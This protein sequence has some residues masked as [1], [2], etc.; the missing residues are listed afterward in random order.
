M[1]LWLCSIDETCAGR[2]FQRL[3][4]RPIFRAVGSADRDDPAQMI[5]RL[6]AVALFDLPQAVIL[7]R[8]HVVRIG[9]QRALV[10]D[11]RKLVVAKLA[12]GVADQ[13]GD[14]R[15]IVVA[16]RLEL[17]DRG[18]IVIAIVNRRVSGAIT[19]AE[20]G[21]V[22]QGLLAG[23]LDPVGGLCSRLPRVGRRRAGRGRVCGGAINLTSAA[24]SATTTTA[25]GRNNL[26]ERERGDQRNRT[27]CRR[28]NPY[29][30]VGHTNLLQLRLRAPYPAEPVNSGLLQTFPER[31][32]EK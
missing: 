19:L 27:R 16:E 2:F 25:S 14:V 1:A 20:R 29:H 12:I 21:V 10:P 24:A 6:I 8:H 11:L 22:E 31:Y 32:S 7:P 15:M 26:S 23:L 5:L 30:Q 28:R 13:I 9:F 18:G 17:I 3:R 4:Q